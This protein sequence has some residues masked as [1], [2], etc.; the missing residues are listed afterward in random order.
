M[1]ERCLSSRWLILIAWFVRAS[2]MVRYIPNDRLGI[3][4]KMWSRQG[5][6]RGGLIALEGEAGFQPEVLRGGF[7]FFVPF[8]Y[9]IHPRRW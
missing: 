7:H 4:E 1:G 6:V 8:Q 3:L 9:R 5:S 2:A